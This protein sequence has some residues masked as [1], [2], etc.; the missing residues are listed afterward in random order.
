MRRNAQ[1]L[2]GISI[3]F[4]A[5]IVL[6]WPGSLLALG[7]G[8]LGLGLLLLVCVALILYTAQRRAH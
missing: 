6:L 7:F 4:A 5:L 3:L 1:Q 2:A 8:A